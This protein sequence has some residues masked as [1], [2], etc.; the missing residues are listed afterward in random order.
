MVD[1]PFPIRRTAA[2]SILAAE[3]RLNRKSGSFLGQCVADPTPLSEKQLNWFLTLAERAG[4]EV[5]T[6]A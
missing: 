4:V 2:L 1:L 6:D 3:A 5:M